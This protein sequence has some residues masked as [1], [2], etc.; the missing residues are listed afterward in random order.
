MYCDKVPNYGAPVRDVA[1]VIMGGRRIRAYT[2]IGSLDG[3]CPYC[4]HEL[5]AWPSRSGPCER[6]SGE[7]LVRTRPLDRERVLVTEREAKALEQQW[8]LYRERGGGSPLRPLLNEEELEVERGRLRVRFGREPSAFDVAASL[9][10]HRAFDHMRRQEMASYR[11]FGLARA[12]LVDQ[13]GRWDEALAGY[14]GVCYLDLNGARNPPQKGPNG[15]ALRSADAANG[16]A[17][18]QA[19][20]APPVV[21]RCIQIIAVLDHD[22]AVVRESFSAFVHRH[23]Q[24]VRAPR[25]PWDVWPE[26]ADAIFSAG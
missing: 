16:F 1:G 2:A 7:I 11:D 20:L 3:L 24:A 5:P 26:L 21:G 18:E 15:E 8:E 9:I 13:Q 10:S 12:A 22:E 4:Q 17:P 25:R 19:C 23:Y 14:L 6:C